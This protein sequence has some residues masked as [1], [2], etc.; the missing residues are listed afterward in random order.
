MW[1]IRGQESDLWIRSRDSGEAD[2]VSC[3]TAST[4]WGRKSSSW[5]L[6]SED[7]QVTALANGYR[8][9][10]ALTNDKRVLLPGS[11]NG[12]REDGKHELEDVDDV[13]RGPR[14]D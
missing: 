10:K 2:Q 7:N 13:G 3:L 6:G 14:L 12:V 11:D 1:Q 5:S 4:I 8:V 9:I